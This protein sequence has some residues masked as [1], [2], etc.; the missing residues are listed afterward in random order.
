[1]I[2]KSLLIYLRIATTTTTTT[3]TAAHHNELPVLPQAVREARV[4]AV[5]AHDAEAVHR[6]QVQQVH[7]VDDQHRV[8]RVLALG[9]L[10]LLYRADG[11]PVQ[12][13]LPLVHVRRRPVAVDAF[14][15]HLSILGGL[16]EIQHERAPTG[17]VSVDQHGDLARSVD[18]VHRM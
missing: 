2:S 15:S 10:E 11:C 3:T 4:V 13:V 5:A 17:V 9:V 1:V 8:G 14:R 12:G 7:R 16:R 6:A 18:G